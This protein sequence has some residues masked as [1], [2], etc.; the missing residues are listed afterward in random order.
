MSGFGLVTGF[1]MAVTS[2]GTA[3][4]QV[5]SAGGL[6]DRQLQFFEGK[7]R[8]LLVKHCYECHSTEAGKAEGNLLLDSRPGLLEGGD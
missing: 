2:P 6:T 4:S 8:P 5:D 3:W 1:M 7:V